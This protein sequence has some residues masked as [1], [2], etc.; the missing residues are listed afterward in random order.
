MIEGTVP[1]E[2]RKRSV[3]WVDPRWTMWATPAYVRRWFTFPLLAVNLV[4]AMPW[5]LRPGSP[6]AE[7]V[8]PM[9]GGLAFGALLVFLAD[10]RNWDMGRGLMRVVPIGAIA[11][12]AATVAVTLRDLVQGT[13]DGYASAAP[14]A[15]A[16]VANGPG[17]G[18]GHFANWAFGSLVIGLVLDQ[19]AKR[20]ALAARHDRQLRE[21]Q[22]AA[23]RARL[24]P[25][26]IFN[27]LGTLQAQIEKDPAAATQTADRLAHLFRQALAAAGRPTV[28][29][30]EE[31]EF[32]EAYLGIERSRLGSRLQVKIDVPEELEEI[33]IPPLSLQV[34]VENAVQHGIAPREDGGEIR[35]RARRSGPGE[36][37][38]IVLSVDNPLAPSSRPGTG[39]GLEALRGRLRT[40][41]DLTT[42]SAAGAFHAEFWWSVA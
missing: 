12:S 34:L 31:L 11:T 2:G 33:E 32:V 8:E 16:V 14:G 30:R 27:A 3:W 23:L 28:P 10:N 19:V 40:P 7:R 37:P 25:H 29:L 9:V 41:G 15:A 38:G 20:R 1:T 42:S 6:I 36:N 21:A 4:A 26:F 18:W 39:T 13:F 17:R 5:P 22:D 24:A 35:I